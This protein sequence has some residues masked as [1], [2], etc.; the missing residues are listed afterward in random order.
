MDKPFSQQQINQRQRK[1]LVKTVIVVAA[2]IGALAWLLASFATSVMRDEIRVAKVTRGDLQTGISASGV[3]MPQFEETVVSHIESQLTKV[4]VQAGQKVIAGQQLVQLATTKL[5]LLLASTDEAIAQKNNQIKMRQ[6]N[7]RQTLNDLQGTVA[8]LKIDLESR[9][10]KHQRIAKLAKFGGSSEHELKEA[11][12]DIKRT[13]IEI[14]QLQQKITN[15]QASTQTQIEGLELEKSILGKTRRENLRLIDSATVKAPRDGLVVWLKNE[16]GSAVSTGEPLVKIADISGYKMDVSLSD[17]YASQVYQGMLTTFEHDNQIFNGVV[18]AIVA[19]D[20]D[21]GLKLR[22][23]L[24]PNLASEKIAL[25]R[26]RLRVD[27][28]LITDEIK[29]TL[30]I[31]KGPFINGAGLQR[32]F[33]V[34]ATTALRTEVN[35]G[36]SNREYYQIKAGLKT[37]D[38]IIIS[39]VSAYANLSQF[40]IK[41]I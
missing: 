13:D 29:D 37:G 23:N 7:L 2:L 14:A 4:M 20:S 24:D 33:V 6:H 39:D 18:N 32:V 40:K 21:G 25:L 36:S 17:F 34:N 8:L 41:G 9:Q 35:V 3:L 19:A 11:T 5:Q 31:A 27:V 30:M 28:N 38:E 1:S 16:E 12:L 10:T 26:Q 15:I 22:V